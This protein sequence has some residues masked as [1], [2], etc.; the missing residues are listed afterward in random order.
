M[1]L[2]AGLIPHGEE[3][4][5]VAG[6]GHGADTVLIIRPEHASNILDTKIIEIIC[7]PRL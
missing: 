1:A 3:I 4:I 2:D 7:K 6:S 5:A